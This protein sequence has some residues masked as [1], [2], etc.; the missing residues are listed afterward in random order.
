MRVP[1]QLRYKTDTNNSDRRT[2]D[3]STD[4]LIVKTITLAKVVAIR[5]ENSEKRATVAER[6]LEKVQKEL[7]EA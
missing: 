6:R 5:V 3:C 2:R 1:D 4:S 7:D